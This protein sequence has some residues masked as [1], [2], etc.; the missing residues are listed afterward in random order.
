MLILSFVSICDPMGCSTS[1]SS[2]HG[3][4]SGKNTGVG[5]HALPGDLP[6]VGIELRSP[7]LQA[8]SLSAE[9]SGK[10]HSGQLL[11]FY[12]VPSLHISI[13]VNKHFMCEL[14]QFYFST[15][16][17]LG[18]LFSYFVQDPLVGH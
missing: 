16:Q 2:V 11:G 14:R 6:N 1:G 15:F 10:P 9:L 8:D 17:A 5:C 7:T 12:S 18:I 3:N 13:Y 4:S